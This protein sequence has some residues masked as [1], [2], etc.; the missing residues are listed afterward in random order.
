[1]HNMFVLPTTT[2]TN[3]W[4]FGEQE[5]LLPL[6]LICSFNFC[7]DP[8][9]MFKTEWL[10]CKCVDLKLSPIFMLGQKTSIKEDIL[11]WL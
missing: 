8:N 5:L 2:P 3:L 1:M 10:F 11:V 7:E 4:R 9:H 6:L